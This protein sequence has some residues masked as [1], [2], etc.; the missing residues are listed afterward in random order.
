MAKK[1]EADNPLRE[2]IKRI[3]EEPGYLRGL[4]MNQANEN[5]RQYQ[6]ESLEALANPIPYTPETSF[7]SQKVD[8]DL[9]KHGYVPGAAVEDEKYLDVLRDNETT[10]TGDVAR[11]VGKVGSELVIG[12]AA[13][14]ASLPDLFSAGY[15][16]AKGD[17]A[18]E[19]EQNELAKALY[20]LNDNIQHA[21]TIQDGNGNF[22]AFKWL[23]NSSNSIASSFALMTG[24]LA[25]ARAGK[26]IGSG[27]SK[28][29][30]MFSEGAKFSK[31]IDDIVAL[32]LSDN[33]K[34]TLLADTMKSFGA[35][36][37]LIGKMLNATS[38]DESV[39]IANRYKHS[40]QF[41]SAIEPNVN[42]SQKVESVIAA[43]GSRSAETLMELEGA[44]EDLVNTYKEGSLKK[45]DLHRQGKLSLE[46]DIDLKLIYDIAYEQYLKKNGLSRIDVE[47]MS[48]EEF[49]LFNDQL[50]YEAVSI[51]ENFEKYDTLKNRFSSVA[52]SQ[53][54]ALAIKDMLLVTSDI[55]G[56]DKLY[57]LMRKPM[58]E[59]ARNTF[60]KFMA[61][62]GSKIA[63]I[64][65]TEGLEE[66]WQ[67]YSQL[68][69]K[70]NLIRQLDLPDHLYR[71]EIT[72]Q[73]KDAVILGALGGVVI[74][75][76]IPALYDLRN[77]VKGRLSKNKEDKPDPETENKAEKIY[78]ST[79]G[80]V[81]NDE[82]NDI[83]PVVPTESPTDVD[84]MSLGEI[85]ELD[86]DTKTVPKSNVEETQDQEKQ[87]EI[88]SE[89]TSSEIND[90]S[91]N[92]GTEGSI[93]KKSEELLS[94]IDKI[95]NIQKSFADIP[96]QLPLT[97]AISYIVGNIGSK[98][99]F[100]NTEEVLSVLD[101]IQKKYIDSHDDQ[102]TKNVFTDLISK[103]K[104]EIPNVLK[105]NEANGSNENTN[106]YNAI[107]SSLSNIFNK[108]I[109]ESLEKELS[110]LQEQLIRKS[111]D[112]SVN[113]N[114][115]QLI[116]NG[117]SHNVLK[118]GILK[119]LAKNKDYKKYKELFES[120]A[121]SIKDESDQK[122]FNAVR[123]VSNLDNY[124]Y[125][126]TNGLLVNNVFDS[127]T[128]KLKTSEEIGDATKDL[129]LVDVV[130]KDVVSNNKSIEDAKIDTERS[131]ASEDIKDQLQQDLE[132]Y[133][134][135]KDKIKV[136]NQLIESI[137]RGENVD[138]NSIPKDILA[139][140]V[141]NSSIENKAELAYKLFH[142]DLAKYIK[143]FYQSIKI[144]K[145]NINLINKIE[146][147][148]KKDLDL[149][150]SDKLLNPN[151]LLKDDII[152]LLNNLNELQFNGN[153]IID[154]FKEKIS[155]NSRKYKK[156]FISLLFNAQEELDSKIKEEIEE[157]IN[158][159]KINEI[160]KSTEKAEEIIN[161]TD[162]KNPSEIHPKEN[163]LSDYKQI[164]PII[165]LEGTKYGFVS[166]GNDIFLY[167]FTTKS[168]IDNSSEITKSLIDKIPNFK[169]LDDFGVFKFNV[170]HNGKKESIA[171]EI[172]DNG[173]LFYFINESTEQL[174]DQIKD[175]II[176]DGDFSLEED[177]EYDIF[178]SL[179]NVYLDKLK[180][181][182]LNKDKYKITLGEEYEI[183][184]VKRSNPNEELFI[185]LYN[186][187][188]KETIV[189]EANKLDLYF[190]DNNIDVSL[191]FKK[192]ND[193]LIIAEE[194]NT[195]SIN[196][197]SNPELI[198]D[199]DNF[200]MESLGADVKGTYEEVFG[201]WSEILNNG[202]GNS[203]FLIS[204]REELND[205]NEYLKDLYNLINNS[206]I[207]NID[208]FKK[209]LEEFIDSGESTKKIEALMSFPFFITLFSNNKAYTVRVQNSYESVNISTAKR[210][211]LR[212]D[213]LA[214]LWYRTNVDEN[215]KIKVRPINSSTQKVK[216]KEKISPK[217][218]LLDVSD[219]FLN[220]SNLSIVIT[221]NNEK[222]EF[223]PATNTSINYDGFKD[224]QY[225]GPGSVFLNFKIKGQTHSIELQGR[226][227]NKKEAVL[228]LI[229]LLSKTD[230]KKLIQ[231]TDKP[232]SI[233]GIKLL[234]KGSEIKDSNTEIILEEEY[235]KL[236]E[237][238]KNKKFH[239]DSLKSFL[240]SALSNSVNILT[241]NDNIGEN[242]TFPIEIKVNKDKIIDLLYYKD[243]KPYI[244]KD[245]RNNSSQFLRDKD[246]FNILL[247]STIRVPMNLDYILDHRED[248]ILD[249][250]S[251]PDLLNP[252]NRLLF[253]TQVDFIYELNISNKEKIDGNNEVKTSDEPNG[254]PT[255]KKPKEVDTKSIEQ[256]N[257]EEKQK[258]I[259]CPVGT[260]NVSSN[261]NVNNNNSNKNS[262][263][264]KYK[265][266][267]NNEDF[268]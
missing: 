215:F 169:I 185:N 90:L 104:E 201:F 13:G 220:Q 264:T 244:I 155:E 188:T 266:E 208:L 46:D 152:S 114:A 147:E 151:K 25:F 159:S 207:S 127:L 141:L 80:N 27:L 196:A 121:E 216:S 254:D 191:F 97:Q 53:L 219:K 235:T 173:I 68:K 108:S 209:K 64:G 74:G 71:D 58:I 259:I 132:E 149:F 9:I 101:N 217:T 225:H 57:S 4:L 88:K 262:L 54:R 16:L 238:I 200:T 73:V 95:E 50:D 252:N 178:K 65:T 93:T 20:D 19:F 60:V 158:K 187:K 55:L 61:D 124:I 236:Y 177:S 84:N 144:D 31:K 211:Q 165:E 117:V 184:P 227:L 228:S 164:S 133:Q 30:K 249:N 18:T 32:G 170:D 162:F 205:K 136:V 59:S 41:M 245:I 96:D 72:S 92:V 49:A 33:V 237:N 195:P 139:K 171:Y 98:T 102:L 167:N 44:R 110:S 34:K 86:K 224:N 176:E 40:M 183:T 168:I 179:F 77:K 174:A 7:G 143:E 126:F 135:Y 180:T 36:D 255:I 8:Y 256:I 37:E 213:L 189:I 251:Y 181:S 239:S 22:R 24:G 120:L 222:K 134:K 146:A 253:S 39:A 250:L 258:E 38:L 106:R 261:N 166:H 232:Y 128:D 81:K 260:K 116:K 218:K 89:E 56:F 109:N 63:F 160:S 148:R 107:L 267:L 115:R 47:N 197:Y 52:D 17:F 26:L 230:I 94:N 243:G 263:R 100:N 204:Y 21:L 242:N 29:G 153:N 190:K 199:S 130:S 186:K 66:G 6:E 268:R 82:E 123:L 85:L 240:I 103:L 119:L 175:K 210:L 206:D 212:K 78:E 43:L 150:L 234:K 241:E 138:Y 76:G 247:K 246:L 203:E 226:P 105:E 125:A 145:S 11:T 51:A 156:S 137:N 248:F 42:L 67:T 193:E 257:I 87:P 140:A 111:D 12:T 70:E 5:A 192:N 2:Y 23:A 48:P 91:K 172:T 75:V 112:M 99:S 15:H 231:Y 79:T 1:L 62:K 69:T 214:A 3:K 198:V 194:L 182:S 233:H 45:L 129:T 202:Y 157:Y 14:L 229:S 221:E 35:R 122:L 142:G 10:F 163:V 131:E 83:P 154:F 161:E 28:I 265:E 223:F 118:H 113:F